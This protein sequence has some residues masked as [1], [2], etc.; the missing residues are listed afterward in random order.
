[1]DINTSILLKDY[2]AMHLGG[3]ARFMAEVTTKEDLVGVI[4]RAQAQNLPFFVLGDGSNVIATD[5]GYEGV[6]ILNRIAGFEVIEDTRYATKIKIGAGEE[7]DGVVERTVGMLLSG[8]EGLSG[9]PGR[10]GATPVQNVG[11]YGQEIADTFVELEAYDLT[12]KTFVTLTKEQCGF[13]YRTSIFKPIRD[14][15]YIIVSVTLLLAKEEPQP[16]FYESLQKY[17]DDKAVTYFTVKVIRDAVL[18][19]RETKLPNPTLLPNSGSFFKNPIIERWQLNDIQTKYPDV[20][21]Y[22][23]ADDTFKIPAGWLIE[24]AGMKGH[25]SHGFKTFETNALVIVNETGTSYKDL[26]LFKAE[27]VNKVLELFRLKLEQE[28]E[29]LEPISVSEEKVQPANAIRRQERPLL[30]QNEPTE[31]KSSASGSYF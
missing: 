7:W 8:I 23:M 2:T 31:D 27:I 12:T 13:G 15:K 22:E 6:I 25:A 21:F 26:E 14:R 29:L 10:T 19:I 16:P 28:P 9:I 17:L 1:M 5:E 11:A 24:T 30:H 4:E 20:P 3:P 18:A